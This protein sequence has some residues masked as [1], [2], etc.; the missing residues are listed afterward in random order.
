MRFL[1]AADIHLD[2]PLRGLDEYEGAPVQALR[3]ATRKAFGALVQLAVSQ[4]VD[5]VILAGDLYDG[6]WPD[7]NT[8]LFFLNRAGDLE[9]AGIPV[10]MLS[11]NHD[12][13]SRITPQLT[14]PANVHAFPTANP[15]TK[16]FE[17]LRVAVHGQGFASQAET[18][19][20]AVTYPAPLPGYFNVGVLH[21]ALD[22]REG[23][24]SYAPC[25]IDDLVARGYDYWA[26]GH[27]HKREAVN[28]T[29]HPRIEYPGNLQGRHA[30]ETGAK[31]CLLVTVDASGN[32]LP[33]F[34][35]LDVF[36]WEIVHV[37]AATAESVSDALES[38]RTTIAEARDNADGR[39]LAARVIIRCSESIALSLASNPEQFSADLRGQVGGDVWIEKIKLAHSRV[40][41]A[42][43]ATLSEDASSEL[44]A[45]LDELQSRPD[46]ARAIFT[47]GDCG[48]LL[49]RLPHDLRAAFEQSWDEVFDRASALLRA[50]AAEPPP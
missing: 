28:G 43:L 21:T 9:R 47:S 14:L 20:L 27:I 37:N 35:P 6:D 50:G 1:H 46:E 24:A 36:R 13:A 39:P 8:G 33:E 40:A 2:S 30:K 26:L 7:F 23:H 25:T 44:R 11:G 18:R 5:F 19:N 34:R 10:V 3:N 42:D 12:A 4:R 31:G 22:G 45:V 41:R 48:K 38:A 49:N 15:G 32:A 16:V 29:R 17:H